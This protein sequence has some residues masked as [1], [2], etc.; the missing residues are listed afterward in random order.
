MAA[1]FEYMNKNKETIKRQEIIGLEWNEERDAIDIWR[2]FGRDIANNVHFHRG[3]IYKAL[4]TLEIMRNIKRLKHGAG[5]AP[6]IYQIISEPSGFEYL[7]LR[8]RSLI[9]DRL[10]VPTQAARIQDTLSRIDVRL[11][12]MEARIK[13]LENRG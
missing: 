4:S 11:K 10:Q 3:A 8:E 5:P 6:S 1:V 2:G 12:E 9:N 7:K 13:I